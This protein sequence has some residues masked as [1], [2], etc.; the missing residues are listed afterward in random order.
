MYFGIIPYYIY[1]WTISQQRHKLEWTLQNICIIVI[2]MIVSPLSLCSLFFLIV[3]MI[4]LTMPL[5]LFSLLLCVYDVLLHLTSYQQLTVPWF[6]FL[7]LS[8]FCF[9][10]WTRLALQISYDI[11]TCKNVHDFLNTYLVTGKEVLYI[12]HQLMCCCYRKAIA[13]NKNYHVK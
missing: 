2:T 9:V 12:V 13:L 1:L 11:R 8:T 4:R 6:C 7:I 3:I 5:L 10:T